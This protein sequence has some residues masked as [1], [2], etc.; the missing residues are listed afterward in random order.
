MN[1]RHTNA[2]K[3]EN[4]RAWQSCPYVHQLTCLVE[5]KHALPEPMEKQGRVIL[6]CPIRGYEQERIP[7]ITTMKVR[8]S[9]KDMRLIVREPEEQP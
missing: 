6:K 3:I 2:E 4:I 5:S 9:E 7:E 1:K 8:L